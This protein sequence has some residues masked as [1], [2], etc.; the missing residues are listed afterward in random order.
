VRDTVLFNEQPDIAISESSWK[1]VTEWAPEEELKTI[2]SVELLIQ[3][4]SDIAARHRRD[5]KFFLEKD[6]SLAFQ[7]YSSFMAAGKI[8]T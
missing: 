4:L 7:E 2:S 3:Q 1:I 6:V 5:A 8:R